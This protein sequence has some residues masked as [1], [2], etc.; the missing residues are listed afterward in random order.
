MNVIDV[1]ADR[2]RREDQVRSRVGHQPLEGVGEVGSDPVVGTQFGEEFRRG[3]VAAVRRLAKRQVDRIADAECTGRVTILSAAQGHVVDL[4]RQ[5]LVELAGEREACRVRHRGGENRRHHD[6]PTLRG[7]P[8]QR[9]AGREDRVVEMGRDRECGARHSRCGSLRKRQS[10]SMGSASGT[11]VGGG[12][13]A[14]R[15]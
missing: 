2:L 13:L 7:E 11:P 4:R 8:R 6:L 14:I 3:G 1:A 10:G 15:S 5:P 9:A 12:S